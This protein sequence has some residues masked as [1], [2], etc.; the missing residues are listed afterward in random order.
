VW[1][2]LS[3]LDRLSAYD[4]GTK[5]SGLTGE[6]AVADDRQLDLLPPRHG[7][8]GSAECVASMTPKPAGQERGSPQRCGGIGDGQGASGQVGQIEVEHLGGG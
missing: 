4:P 7:M 8:S 6:R 3:T 2:T 1:D 5:A